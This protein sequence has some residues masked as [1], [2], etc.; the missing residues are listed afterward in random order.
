MD[1]SELFF[2]I[3]KWTNVCDPPKKNIDAVKAYFSINPCGTP[4]TC[5]NF[6]EKFVAYFL[7][8]Y[9]ILLLGINI[10][11]QENELFDCPS[12]RKLNIWTWNKFTYY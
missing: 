6:M 8:G 12:K 5:C 3:S 1:L 4:C 7:I 2:K 11:L 9:D 10:Y